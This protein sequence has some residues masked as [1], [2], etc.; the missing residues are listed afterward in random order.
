MS[1]QTEKSNIVGQCV[2]IVSCYQSLVGCFASF[3]DATQVAKTFIDKGRICDI[4]CQIIK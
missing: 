4:S 1:Q 3:E 2:Y